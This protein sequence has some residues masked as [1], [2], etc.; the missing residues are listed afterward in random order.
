MQVVSSKTTMG[1]SQPRASAKGLC[2]SPRAALTNASSTVHNK[3]SPCPKCPKN[4]CRD[5]P[6]KSRRA[7][8]SQQK[9]ADNQRRGELTL[10]SSTLASTLALSTTIGAVN[11]FKAFLQGQADFFSTLNLP[12]WLVHYNCASCCMWPSSYYRDRDG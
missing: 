1:L 4:N 6:T 2:K 5:C 12:D 11:P 9:S 7:V 3:K 8:S 10:Q